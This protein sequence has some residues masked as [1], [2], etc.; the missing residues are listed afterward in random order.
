LKEGPGNRQDG[1]L[2]AVSSG[3]VSETV[4]MVGE[5]DEG[6]GLTIVDGRIPSKIEGER[7]VSDS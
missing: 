6:R 4:E 5:K 1:I 3:G 7:V 2:P